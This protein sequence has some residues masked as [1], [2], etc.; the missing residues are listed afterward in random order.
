MFQEIWTRIAGSRVLTITPWNL[1][2]S[3][4]LSAARERASASSASICPIATPKT[5]T[6]YPRWCTSLL[7]SFCSSPLIGSVHSHLRKWGKIHFGFCAREEPTSSPLSTTYSALVKQ[8]VPSWAKIS[9]NNSISLFLAFIFSHCSKKA[10][11][12]QG[13]RRDFLD[14][15]VFQSYKLPS[16][17]AATNSYL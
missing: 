2:G 1:F 4:L 15:L 5:W 14:P 17:A 16:K 13:R 3:Y 6:Q 7:L 9:A 10:D 8:N 11:G 12:C